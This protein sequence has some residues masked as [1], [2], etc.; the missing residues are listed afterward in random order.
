MDRSSNINSRSK[1]IA[2]KKIVSKKDC[3]NK[4]KFECTKT[5]DATEQETI[6]LEFYNR[7]RYGKQIL[8]VKQRLVQMRLKER[9]QV[10]KGRSASISLWLEK[11][12][13]V[14][15]KAFICPLLQSLKK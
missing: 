13:F 14:F 2:A 1:K 6:F 3:E 12:H 4:F 10:E 7:D 8:L 15:A 9:I 5:I 11:G